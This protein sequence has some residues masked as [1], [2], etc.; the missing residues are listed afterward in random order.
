MPHAARLLA[1]AR[2]QIASRVSG[3]HHPA[4]G[5]RLRLEQADDLGVGPG[6]AEQIALPLMAAFGAQTAQFRFGLD[7]LR[8]TLRIQLVPEDVD[9]F[10]LPSTTLG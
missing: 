3:H 6:T 10:L 9:R 4:I 8:A 7:A 1:I 2:Q 5:R